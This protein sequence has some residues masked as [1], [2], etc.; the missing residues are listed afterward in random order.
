MALIDIYAANG[1][2][3]NDLLFAHKSQPYFTWSPYFDTTGISVDASHLRHYNAYYMIGMPRFEFYTRMGNSYRMFENCYSLRFI[4]SGTIQTSGLELAN[5]Y[6]IKK[7]SIAVGPGNRMNLPNCFNLETLP[8]H[9]TNGY[10]IQLTTTTKLSDFKVGGIY[11]NC[12]FAGVPLLTK[13]SLI[14]AIEHASQ[15]GTQTITLTAERYTT[16]SADP[17]VEAALI[18]R[19]SVVLASA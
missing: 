8:E 11:G 16:L 14:Y 13:E 4:N 15:S 7:F 17:D 3:N 12:S 2:W 5:C 6:S 19:G 9:G 1:G 18:A 10:Q